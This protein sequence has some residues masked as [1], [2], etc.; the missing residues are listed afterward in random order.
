M[1]LAVVDSKQPETEESQ[2]YCAT[3]DREGTSECV[4]LQ[5]GAQIGQCLNCDTEL[6]E[7]GQCPR[8][9]PSPNI[10]D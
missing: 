4:A 9:P 7:D 10:F 3:C 1:G 5:L 8:C 2:S 6:N